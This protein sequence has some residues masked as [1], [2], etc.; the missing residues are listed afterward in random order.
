MALL[1]PTEI[2]TG[3]TVYFLKRNFPS[4]ARIIGT[5]TEFTNSSQA[6]SYLLEGQGSKEFVIGDENFSLPNMIYTSAEDFEDALANRI[7]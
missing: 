1:K 7:E 5:N 2:Q 3:E 6:D 4:T